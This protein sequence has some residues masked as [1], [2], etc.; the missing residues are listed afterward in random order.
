MAFVKYILE[1]KIPCPRCNADSQIRAE[2][3]GDIVAV[4]HVCQFCRFRKFKRITTRRALELEKR[5]KKY[6]ELLNSS[7]KIEKNYKIL[8]RLKKIQKER[9]LLELGIRRKNGRSSRAK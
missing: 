8:A 2:D 4:Y 1:D 7:N 9:Q 5:E 6:I 3:K